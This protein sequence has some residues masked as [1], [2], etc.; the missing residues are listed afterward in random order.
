MN[1]PFGGPLESWRPLER[2][3]QRFQVSD[4][5]LECPDQQDYNGSNRSVQGGPIPIQPPPL[6]GLELE[7]LGAGSWTEP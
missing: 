4:S 2:Q 6:R 7:G 5:S 1:E 3:F